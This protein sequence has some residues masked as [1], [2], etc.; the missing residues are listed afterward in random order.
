MVATGALR[1]SP[2]EAFRTLQVDDVPS[3]G[4]AQRLLACEEALLT[5]RL[6]EPMSFSRI[7]AS[8]ANAFCVVVLVA[9][10]VNFCEVTP[11]MLLQ[12]VLASIL[13]SSCE[14]VGLVYLAVT[15]VVLVMFS[16][17]LPQVPGACPLT[18]GIAIYGSVVSSLVK[19]H[20]SLARVSPRAITG[21]GLPTV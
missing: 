1:S 18:C 6:S 8:M 15:I 7:W 11:L 17:M 3:L 13:V 16:C 9:S 2:R 19:I 20:G 4:E 21:G 14:E 10:T 5:H 12:R